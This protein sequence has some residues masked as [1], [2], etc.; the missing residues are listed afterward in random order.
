MRFFMS[1]FVCVCVCKMKITGNVFLYVLLYSDV[2]IE[3]CYYCN[4]FYIFM[5][6]TWCKK[7]NA[8]FPQHNVE[9]NLLIIILS[10]KIFIN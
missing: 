10:I 6:I 3:F 7:K 8:E 5:S 9:G 2:S 1:E 4:C